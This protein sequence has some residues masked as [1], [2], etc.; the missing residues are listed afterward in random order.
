MKYWYERAQQWLE[1]FIYPKPDHSIPNGAGAYF[2]NVWG[3]HSMLQLIRNIVAGE[4]CITYKQLVKA[5]E[6]M[7]PAALRFVKEHKDF[8]QPAIDEYVNDTVTMTSSLYQ[9]CGDAVNDAKMTERFREAVRGY[10]AEEL[11]TLGFLRINGNHVEAAG[12]NYSRMPRTCLL[13]EFEKNPEAQI[14]MIRYG[15]RIAK[16]MGLDEK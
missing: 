5:V 1:D 2:Q 13:T 7:Y 16:T 14:D 4:N 9:S 11:V 15:T 12:P 6:E 3:E 8:C 10:S